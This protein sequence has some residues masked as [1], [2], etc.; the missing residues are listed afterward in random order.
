MSSTAKLCRTI[1]AR[2]EAYKEMWQTRI[3]C[4]AATMLYV[5]IFTTEGFM[6]LI[7]IA[8][9]IVLLIMDSDIRRKF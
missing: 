9:I 7:A 5:S 4:V 3:L 1:K 8:I 2:K 6:G